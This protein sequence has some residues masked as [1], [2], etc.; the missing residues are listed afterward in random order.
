MLRMKDSLKLVLFVVVVLFQ[1][2]TKA[3][4]HNHGVT[5]IF[6]T[7][8][9]IQSEDSEEEI[10]SMDNNCLSESDD[11][12]VLAEDNYFSLSFSPAIPP[13]GDD[14]EPRNYCSALL[15]PPKHLV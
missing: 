5:E 3:D 7:F 12:D 4:V 1:G 6:A 10:P 9:S 2:L 14:S 13:S 15:K 8:T 11:P